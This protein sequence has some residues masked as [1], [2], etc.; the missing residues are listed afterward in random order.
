MEYIKALLALVFVLSLIGLTAFLL[1]RYGGEKFTGNSGNAKR[2][3]AIKEVLALDTRRRIVLISRDE[4]EHLILL[5]PDHATVIE[6][7]IKSRNFRPT[8]PAGNS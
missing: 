7:Y 6:K 8:R 3:L 4:V 2:R 1:R 5:G